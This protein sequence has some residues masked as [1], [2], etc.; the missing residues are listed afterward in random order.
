MFLHVEFKCLHIVCE[1]FV[2]FHSV[3]KEL[4]MT[5]V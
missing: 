2:R 3:Q 1:I 5:S 4:V